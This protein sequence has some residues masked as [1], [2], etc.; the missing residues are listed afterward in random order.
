MKNQTLIYTVPFSQLRDIYN[1][2]KHEKANFKELAEAIDT[3]DN[4]LKLKE[5][6]IEGYISVSD[7]LN[8]NYLEGYSYYYDSNYYVNTMEGDIEH[9]DNVYFCEYY[10][11]YTSE[12]TSVVYLGSRRK[13]KNYSAKAIEGLNLYCAPDGDYYDCD[14]LYN[15]GYVIMPNGEIEDVDNVYYWESDGEYH[16]DPEPS[17]QYVREYH[18]DTSVKKVT[19]SEDPKFFIGFE[20]E[21]EDKEVKESIDIDDFEDENPNWRKERDGSLDDESGYELI[22]PCYELN[23]DE[24]KKDIESSSTIVEHINAEKSNRCGG[25]INISE[26]GLTGRELFEKI[27]GYTPLFHA[28]YYKRTETRY[29]KGKSNKDLKESGEKFQSVKIHS[30]RVEYRIVSAVPNLN[31]LLWRARLLKYIV[32]NPTASPTRAFYYIQNGL[33]PLLSEMY[34]NEKIN[35]LFERVIEFTEKYENIKLSK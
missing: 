14:A 20:I 35:V 8:C 4:F 12:E 31:T 23:I 5:S 25:H 6:V 29:S 11:E 3:Y 15:S 22:S 16:Y 24:I 19:F 28:L 21:K 34:P 17:E 1:F 10:E 27:E 9:I 26:S 13:S 32:E 2:C 33:K 30:N 7:Y 18:H